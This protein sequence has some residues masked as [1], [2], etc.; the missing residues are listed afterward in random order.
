MRQNSNENKKLKKEKIRIVSAKDQN[1]M[2]V[3]DLE[4]FYFTIFG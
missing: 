2:G 4:N 3:K 1:K